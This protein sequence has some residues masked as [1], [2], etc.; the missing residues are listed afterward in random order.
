LGL[1]APEEETKNKTWLGILKLIMGLKK[2]PMVLLK[3]TGL[4]GYYG[5]LS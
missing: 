2:T 4:V 3:V 5:F 1:S